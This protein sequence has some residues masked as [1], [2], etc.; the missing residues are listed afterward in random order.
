MGRG[1]VGRVPSPPELLTNSESVLIAT[2]RDANKYHS[3][4][5]AIRTI[6]PVFPVSKQPTAGSLGHHLR[7]FQYDPRLPALP[8]G[9]SSDHPGPVGR[10]H[11]LDSRTPP[12]EIRR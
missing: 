12:V 1:S 8:A 3:G 11:F 5:I 10:H 6:S 4:R 7:R 9:I 2:I